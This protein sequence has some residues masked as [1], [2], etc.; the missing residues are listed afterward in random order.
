MAA[1]LYSLLVSVVISSAVDPYSDPSKKYLEVAMLQAANI[2][3][4]EICPVSGTMEVCQSASRIT[5]SKETL[6][7]HVCPADGELLHDRYVQQ[8][9]MMLMKMNVNKTVHLIIS[10]II[11]IFERN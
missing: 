6:Y 4:P 9:C 11:F 7:V 1:V 5:S 8:I 10:H 2:N 3:G